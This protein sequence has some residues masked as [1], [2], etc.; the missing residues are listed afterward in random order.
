[1]IDN[2]DD[3][4]ISKVYDKYKE[5]TNSELAKSNVQDVVDKQSQTAEFLQ[6]AKDGKL[7]Y[8][9]YLERKRNT[10]LNSFPNIDKYND[11][12]KQK[13]KQGIDTLDVDTTNRLQQQ[14]LALPNKDDAE[15]K[16]K[17]KEFFT[18]FLNVS[19]IKTEQ[20]TINDEI[21]TSSTTT[22]LK[23]AY[24]PSD[25]DRLMTFEEVF[26]AEQGV[27]FNKDNIQKYNESVAKFALATKL[28]SA[29]ETINKNISLA[30]ERYKVDS[31]TGLN[32]TDITNSN[33]A[34]TVGSTIM[35]LY[36][37]GNIAKGLADLTDGKYTLDENTN[38][39]EDLANKYHGS[40][41]DIAKLIQTKIN[42]RCDK[43]MG[44]KSLDDYAKIMAEDYKNAYGFRD[45]NAL[46][47]AFAQDQEGIVQTARNGVQI[48][49]TVVMVGG[50]AFC[51]PAALGG[52]LIASFGGIGVEALN[53]STKQNASPEKMNELKKEFAQNVA[54]FAV[55]AGAG[56]L[57]SSA[58]A[59]LTAN[60]APK[61]V[62]MIGDIGVD[63]TVSL[64]GDLVLTGQLDITGEGFSQ[65]M[66]LIAGHK[67][68]IVKGVQHLKE[69][70][71]DKF[72]LQSENPNKN[73][74]QMPNGTLVEVKPD[75]S[76]VEVKADEVSQNN[77][78]TEQPIEWK[79][80]NI[81]GE[82]IE[83]AMTRDASGNT[84]V[85]FS[86]ARKLNA[87]VKYEEFS[88]TTQEHLLADTSVKNEVL[89]QSKVL[90]IYNKAN[91]SDEQANQIFKDLQITDRDISGIRW[92][93]DS[94]TNKIAAV[95]KHISE[96]SD[97]KKIESRDLKDLILY[98]IDENNIGLVGQ[99]L[100]NT[101]DIDIFNILGNIRYRNYNKMGPD[102]RLY[103]TDSKARI[104]A[105]Q[106]ILNSDKA[107]LLSEILPQINS[108]NK[109]DILNFYL[110][111][112]GNNE[113]LTETIT[114]LKTLYP[115]I[116]T[117]EQFCIENVKTPE[118]ANVLNKLF[119]S[120]LEIVGDVLK[121]MDSSPEIAKQFSDFA[122]KDINL[123]LHSK[124][125]I[126]S[127]AAKDKADLN[128]L[129]NKYIIEDN[130]VKQYLSLKNIDF[131]SNDFE[132]YQRNN[133]EE[134][135]S[136]CEKTNTEI[137]PKNM[138]FIDNAN[139]AM[140]ENLSFRDS[141]NFISEI[142]KDIKPEE[143]NDFLS[144]V[145]YSNKQV[146]KIIEENHYA[147]RG[148]EVEQSIKEIVS[149]YREHPKEVLTLS[150]EKMI[151]SDGKEEPKFVP[152]EILEL[153]PLM[154]EYPTEV[155]S[156]INEKVV[157]SNGG[158]RPR[159]ESYEI[160]D[161]VPL[162]KEYPTEVASLINEKVV[163]SN[164]GERP[165]FES[166]EIRDLVPLMKKYPTEVSS[167]INEKFVYS[168][169]KE[170]P[171]FESSDIFDLTPVM[172][173]YPTE[174]SLLTKETV[175]SYEKEAP[176]FI[177]SDI[178]KLAPVMKDYPEEISALL[179]VNT[180]F[181]PNQ[182]I[183]LVPAMVK[184]SEAVL[185]LSNYKEID[186]SVPEISELG[187]VEDFDLKSIKEQIAKQL[188]TVKANPEKYINGEYSNEQEMLGEVDNFF[189]EHRKLLLKA[190]AVFDKEALNHLLRM[191]FDD[192]SEYLDVLNDLSDLNL[193]KQL[194]NSTNISGKPFMPTQKVEFIDL[195]NAYKD[196]GLET[197][198]IEQMV[199]NGKVDLAQLNM[200]LFNKIMKNSGLTDSEI[201]TIPKEK[202]AAW[203][204]KYA[205]LL[206]KEI[207]DEK[208]PAFSDLL[209]TANLEPDFNK[210]IHDTNNAYGQVNANTKAMYQENNM[211]YDSWLKPAKENEVHFVSKDKNTEQLN[212]IASQVA[213][214][215]NTLM[216]TPVKGF[217]KKQY[218]AKFFKGDEF[219]IPQEYMSNKSKLTE[220]VKQLSDTSEQG[221]LMQ[222]W[223][224]AKGNST[225]PDANRA[226]TA[227]N[228]L[229]ILDHL[230][231]RLD[232]LSNVQDVKAS[233]TLD[234]TIKMWDRNPQKDIFQGN[235]S[236][237]CIGMGGGNGS[238]MPYFVM[239]TAYN[240][241]ELVDNI[242]GKTIGNALCY[243]VKGENG[244]PAFIID[245]IEI[246]N[247]AKP[248][249]E[250]GK[251]IRTSMVEYAS[252]VAKGVTGSDDVP[253]YMSN[254]Y[255]DVPTSDLFSSR[256]NVLFMG[257]VNRDDI[258][259]D[260]YTGWIDKEE[261][262]RPHNVNL[263]KLK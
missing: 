35:Q 132:Q 52:G 255:N 244:K 193:I 175:N 195:L 136:L 147:N 45:A 122:S 74:M 96:N 4:V 178:R 222:V 27:E 113:F 58:K 48:V 95:L 90:E 72:R 164:G 111:T 162:M 37:R 240:M 237:C 166:Y 177:V 6:E 7:T 100:T 187:L 219:V 99:L 3:G 106:E 200:D 119:S 116:S 205:H 107:E 221:Q 66:S 123:L 9:D 82:D 43:A 224:R 36:G 258:Y 196:N 23:K 158:E 18:E 8:K 91:L 242:T 71:S 216:K 128:E 104:E 198:K 173:E 203:D 169:G 141:K 87:D 260:L 262:M 131:K 86:R 248:S 157:T 220:L 168:N 184:N 38:S 231:Q 17:A 53:E 49:G 70:V 83:V 33:L 225:N 109:N 135:L 42:E 134:I 51:P 39:L 108:E 230:T 65:V 210:Y 238:A 103:E 22:R 204:I 62:A 256:E 94:K 232:D 152:Y 156:L 125:N 215:I 120:N 5:A 150:R 110:K 24:N 153:A 77:H 30:L 139:K 47:N 261:F 31:S 180:K 101:K 21:S 247:G 213:E 15:Y 92:Y 209:R 75:G 165:R 44:G 16:T 140:Q 146:Q 1:M 144:L 73:I 59:M 129:L 56:K 226:Q 130:I 78:S 127:S 117:I 223:K 199:Q 191:R 149:L 241:I 253:I 114:N 54:L 167:L 11:E 171:R 245:N 190:G 202:L 182:I 155:S 118:Q 81:G 126:L 93:K 179:K 105:T 250:V 102:S 207:A 143:Q 161:L 174:V 197:I 208:D 239:D 211:N 98:Y 217:L 121:Y 133:V 80:V 57:G 41:T 176:R 61:F 172:K 60:N 181:T 259:M 112:N 263:L 192:A 14:I 26:K 89:S 214:D 97:M 249:D 236:T 185:A 67:G 115:D 228:T 64:I 19:T 68:K 148:L 257:D 194:S 243:M 234:L 84:N 79:K 40:I 28:N 246:N 154:K 2:Q 170:R 145:E 13:I 142:L 63:S 227:R 160:R 88:A 138:L 163:T 25:G 55:G 218:S 69:K 186:F 76:T 252:N 50:M 85:D 137:N 233:K 188:E 124:I 20:K 29:K 229:T 206:S 235:Y 151:N 201:A 34:L 251:Q 212:Q 254:Q 46:A 183:S 159:F 12:Q 10:L 32:S 189:R